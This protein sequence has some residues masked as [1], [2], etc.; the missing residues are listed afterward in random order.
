MNLRLPGFAAASAV[1]AGGAPAVRLGS[2]GRLGGATPGFFRDVSPQLV[3]K[4]RAGLGRGLI[5]RRFRSGAN[6]ACGLVSRCGHT[7]LPNPNITMRV[8]PKT[9]RSRRTSAQKYH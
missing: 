4:L 2:A 5:L 1:P 3:R 7:G 9:G 6:D 8:E